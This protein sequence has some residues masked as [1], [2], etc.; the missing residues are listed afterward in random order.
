MKEISSVAAGAG[1]ELVSALP[2]ATERAPAWRIASRWR[3]TVCATEFVRHQEKISE[4]TGSADD[5]NDT[6]FD[7]CLASLHSLKQELGAAV[8]G[9]TSS[10]TDPRPGSVL[11]DVLGND[12]QHLGK[13]VE[14]VE[15][16]VRQRVQRQSTGKREALNRAIEKLEDIAGGKSPGGSWKEKLGASS[17]WDEV[18]HEAGYHLIVKVDETTSRPLHEVLDDVFLEIKAARSEYEK[19]CQD[20]FGAQIS[21]SALPDGLLPVSLTRR[22]EEAQKKAEIT[23]TESFFYDIV[24]KSG[25]SRF[26]QVQKR[27]E[28]MSQRGIESDSL[29]PAIWR[30]AQLLSA[31]RRRPNDPATPAIIKTHGK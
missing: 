16:W 24:L 9:C 6:I 15:K 5:D 3:A 1:F 31:S 14:A 12:T 29:Q 23:H 21:S 8:S 4:L 19:T 27:M 7:Q 11:K 22:I 30:K 18:Q 10:S 17:T 13:A 25:A 2:A 20:M 26:V 28:S